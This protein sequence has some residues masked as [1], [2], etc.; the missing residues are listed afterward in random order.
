MSQ[1]TLAVGTKV[2]CDPRAFACPKEKEDAKVGSLKL[3][4]LLSGLSAL[5]VPVF[6][7][8]PFVHLDDEAEQQSWRTVSTLAFLAL[9]TGMV[10]VLYSAARIQFAFE[11]EFGAKGL[12]MAVLIAAINISAAMLAFA[13]AGPCKRQAEA[14]R[15]DRPHIGLG[16]KAGGTGAP[17]AGPPHGDLGLIPTAPAGG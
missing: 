14:S 12:D 2:I 13:I 5:V 9:G 1:T 4:L 8:A 15:I 10:S 7:P 6:L 11:K 16:A 3:L 17:A